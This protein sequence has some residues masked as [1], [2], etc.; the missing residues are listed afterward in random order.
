MSE[1]S[2]DKHEVDS[3]ER[4]AKLAA[5]AKKVIDDNRRAEEMHIIAV[6]K[7]AAEA[8]VAEAGVGKTMVEIEKLSIDRDHA[9]INLR[10]QMMQEAQSIR[11]EEAAMAS[12]LFHNLY[13][14]EGDISERS[15]ADC[16]QRLSYWNRTK[17][18][19]DIEIIFSS[20]GGSVFAGMKLY[21]YIQELKRARTLGNGEVLPG[22]KVTTHTLGMA[23]S[24][25]GILLQAGSVRAMG[26]EA[27]ILI[28]EISTIT[29]GSASQIEDEADLLKRMQKRVTDIFMHGVAAASKAGTATKPVTRAAFLKAWKRKDWWVTSDEA[30]EMGLVD[31]VR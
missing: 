28:H 25:A 21:D 8:A 29:G 16:I 6:K 23:A 30:L 26:K 12:D 27:L 9:A 17:P 31:V 2:D 13:F 5:E 19:T 10:L 7:A 20:Q 24:M 11:Q 4:N 3:P 1:E 18:G 14:F 15:V 22:H